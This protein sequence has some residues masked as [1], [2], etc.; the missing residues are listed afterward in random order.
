MEVRRSKSG[1]TSLVKS[2][3]VEIIDELHA[4]GLS[5]T[6]RAKDPFQTS[7]GH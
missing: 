1:L 4:K 6:Y 7:F 3:V 2:Y 5:W